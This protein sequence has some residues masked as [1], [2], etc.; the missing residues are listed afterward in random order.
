MEA[1]L[2]NKLGILLAAFGSSNPEAHRSL[3]RFDEMVRERFPDIP[4]R[5][6]FTSGFIRRRLADEGKKTDS[7]SK[8]LSKMWFEKYTH[9]V[10]QSLHMVPGAEYDLLRDDALGLDRSLGP[11]KPGPEGTPDMGFERVVVGEPLM[12]DDRDVLLAARA[13][14]RHLPEERKPGQPVILMGHGTWHKGDSRYESLSE[15]V[16]EHDPHIYLGTMD[17][18]RTIEDILQDLEAMP[19]KPARAWLMPLL[20]VAGAHVA[21]DMAGEQPDSWMSRIQAQGIPC[22][23][24]LKGAAEYEGFVDI[25]LEHLRRAVDHLL[26]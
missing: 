5:W 4:V 21:R 7:V 22:I 10:V 18:A 2:S 26:V 6:A 25:W 15:A 3:W 8:G 1:V 9:V 20:A 12:A 24:I 11:V 13:L 19:A 16:R 17:G 14:L 23:P